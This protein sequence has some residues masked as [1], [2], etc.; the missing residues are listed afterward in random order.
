MEIETTEDNNIY[1]DLDKLFLRD[2]P[3]ADP[4]FNCSQDQHVK[5]GD[6][7]SLVTMSRGKIFSSKSRKF[8]WSVPVGLG[9]RSLRTS[10]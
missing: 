3:Y 9:V 2:S 8:W 10:R 4:R 1:A 6:H 5:V 7:S